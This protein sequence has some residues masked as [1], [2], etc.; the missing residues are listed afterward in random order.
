MEVKTI[1]E[2]GNNGEQI[3]LTG[4]LSYGQLTLKRGMTNTFDLWNWMNAT[5]S[6]SSLRARKAEVVVFAADGKTEQ[7]RFI[8]NR[9]MPIKLRHPL[10][11]QRTG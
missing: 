5:L 8:L 2:G 11:T 4:P 9:C 7:V 1:R 10:S 3:C 6:D